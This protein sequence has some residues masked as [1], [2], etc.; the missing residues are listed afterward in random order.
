MVR[1]ARHRHIEKIVTDNGACYRVEAF[2]RA[3]LGAKHKRTT[4]YT[5]KHNGKVERYNR[6]LTE[7]YL[8]VPAEAAGLSQAT[9]GRETVAVQDNRGPIRRLT[10][11]VR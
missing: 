11:L 4:P 6:I 7:E 9:Q 2:A 3:L 8:S 5:P 1:H 10:V